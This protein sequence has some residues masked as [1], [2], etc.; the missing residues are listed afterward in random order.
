MTT[1][2][3]ETLI[4]ESKL[5]SAGEESQ[6]QLIEADEDTIYLFEENNPKDHYTVWERK[7]QTDQFE[8]VDSTTD[9]K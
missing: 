7:D 8:Q 2:Y 9:P 6:N 4:E 1:C 3:S 5:R